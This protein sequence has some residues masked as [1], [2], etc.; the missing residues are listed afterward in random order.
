[1]ALTYSRLR[2]PKAQG[3]CGCVESRGSEGSC[4]QRS[5]QLW[6]RVPEQGRLSCPQSWDREGTVSYHTLT[7]SQAQQTTPYWTAANTLH[8]RGCCRQQRL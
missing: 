1:M 4:P 2:G 3:G 6:L 7:S 8:A 5:P